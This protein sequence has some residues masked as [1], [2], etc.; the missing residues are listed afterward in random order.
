VL[1]EIDNPDEA[2]VNDIA[3]LSKLLGRDKSDFRPN[4]IEIIVVG[5]VFL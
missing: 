3:L 2:N 1:D 4:N 5:T